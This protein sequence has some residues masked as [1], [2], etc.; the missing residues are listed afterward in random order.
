MRAAV[1]RA[2]ECLEDGDQAGATLILLAALEDE[3]GGPP[4]CAVCG[5][6]AWPGDERAHV[7]S[8]HHEL[9]RAA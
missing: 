8:L 6:R 2:L 1:V 9:R 3:P 4:V 7:F 5:V